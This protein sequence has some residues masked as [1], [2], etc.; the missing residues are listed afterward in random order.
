VYVVASHRP[1]SAW[2]S[3]FKHARAKQQFISAHFLDQSRRLSMHQ[4]ACVER[5]ETN[6]PNIR[7]SSPAE[8]FSHQNAAA[9]NE[10]QLSAR[11]VIFIND[12]ELFHLNTAFLKTGII[13]TSLS[14]SAPTG[15]VVRAGSII[16]CR[17]KCIVLS[18]SHRP[19]TYTDFRTQSSHSV[20]THLSWSSVLWH[21]KWKEWSL[22]S[23]ELL[24]SSKQETY[25]FENLQFH[26]LW[27]VIIILNN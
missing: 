20:Y 5:L 2:L 27:L 21:E 13:P 1:G 17:E 18:T 15:L 16:M 3:A 25:N 14:C 19:I 10:I 26:Q 9:L 24:I 11:L 6:D 4:R 22:I 12:R 7:V 8:L 23:T